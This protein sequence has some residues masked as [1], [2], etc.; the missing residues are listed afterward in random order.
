MRKGTIFSIIALLAALVGIGVALS[1]Y[2]NKKRCVMCE[3]FSDDMTDEN[4]NDIEYFATDIEDPS[5]V[6][7]SCDCTC[8]CEEPSDLAEEARVQQDSHE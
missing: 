8:G 2:F 3:D 5:H 6:Q 4:P 7:E 1:A